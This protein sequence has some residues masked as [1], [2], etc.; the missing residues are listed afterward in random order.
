LRPRPAGDH[1]LVDK[2]HHPLSSTG[3]GCGA[4]AASAVAHLKIEPEKH[5]TW[6][7]SQGDDV[8]SDEVPASLCGLH[9]VVCYGQGATGI[10]SKHQHRFSDVCPL[11][12]AVMPQFAQ[13]AG[14]CAKA[15]QVTNWVYKAKTAKL[16]V[17]VV[18]PRALKSRATSSSCSHLQKELYELIV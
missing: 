17:V 1:V 18:H 10:R 2:L 4:A 9:E 13:S 11:L 6:P 15:Q 16:C 14:L 7:Q 8:V 12:I 3:I 5:H